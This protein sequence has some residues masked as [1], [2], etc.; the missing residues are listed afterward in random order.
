MSEPTPEQAWQQKLDS[1][2]VA[3][4]KE[5]DH[6]AK[7][8]IQQ[9]IAEARAKL[10]EIRKASATAPENGPRFDISRIDKF[11]PALLVGRE[12][13]TALLVDAWDRAVRD[14]PNRPRVLTFVALG[15]EGKTSLVAKWA[16]QL[17]GQ[18]WPGCE[19]CFAW[20]FYSQGTRD[21]VAASSDLFLQVAL[22]F[23]GDDAD[24][25]FAVS[26]AA[27]YEKGQRLARAVGRRRCLLIL[28]GLEPL[29]YAPTAPTPGELKDQGVSALLRGLAADSRGLCVV[30]T[31]HSLPDLKAFWQST[32]REEKLH[33]LSRP[34]G[35]HLLKT[36][37]V[38]GSDQR[39]VPSADGR[40]QL[41]EFE[42]L[43]EDARGHALT[44]TLLGTFLAEFHGG[45]IRRRDRVK[46]KEA[47]AT[48][49][50]PH[51]AWRVMD[52]YVRA[53]AP[54]GL[55]AWVRRLFRRAAR[56][57][58]AEG[59]RAVSVLR[60]VGFFDRP[61]DAGCFGA[62]WNAPAIDGLT[63]SLVGL[64]EPHRNGILKRLEDARLVTVN[65]DAG[66][67]LVSVDA[68][69]L[70]REYFAAQLREAKSGAW[71][72]GHRRLFEH[73][74]ATTTEGQE[75]TLDALQPLYQAVAHGCHAGMHR[76]ACATVYF[77]RIQRGKEG[78]STHKL[79]AF[80]SDLGA[81]TCFFEAPWGRV[82]AAFTEVDQA[83]LLNEA[84]TRLR[85]LGRL[86]EA[87]EPTRIALQ[88]RVRQ[89]KWKN[90]A[91]MASNLSQLRL[92]LGEVSGAAGDAQQSVA[93]ADRS[94][95]AFQRMSKRTTHADALHQWGRRDEALALFRQAE[96]MQA[97]DQP[98]YPQLY[99][100][101]GF[102]YCD[103]LL[104]AAERA[105]WGP[106][107]GVQVK[108]DERATCRDVARHA[109]RT[110][111][112]VESES[113]LLDIAL[114]HLT[115]GR[116]ALLEAL[117]GG[118]DF[119]IA[120]A[121]LDAAVSGL[122]RAGQQY[123]LP[124]GLLARAWLRAVGGKRTGPDS[125]Q[126]DLDEAWEIAERGPMPLHMADIHLYR[127]RLF[128]REPAYPWE[129][130]AAD[131]A[132]AEKLIA[133]CGYHRRDEELADAKRL[134]LPNNVKMLSP[135]RIEVPMP[136]QSS[137]TPEDRS[138]PEG[139]REP[140][141]G[142]GVPRTVVVLATGWGPLY[143]GINAF[144]F[145]LCHALGTVLKGAARLVCVTAGV[146]DLT[147]SRAERDHLRLLTLPKVGPGDEVAVARNARDL[148]AQNGITATDLVIGHDVVTGPAAVELCALTGGRS[149]V[150]HH[151]SYGEYQ[152]VKKDGRT[153]LQMEDTQ[154]ELLR[155]AAVVLAV[156]PLLR[157]SAEHLVG[158]AV[159]M[160]VPGLAAI[161]P[162]ER[163]A[164]NAFRGIAFGRLGGEDD[165]I[166]QGSLAV[167]GYG[168]YVK[169][170]E[171]LN[172]DRDHRFTMYGLPPDRYADEE[173]A[174]K[175]LMRQEAGRQIAVNATVY[176]DDRAKLYAALAD[177]EVALMLSWHE[178][179]GLVGW[180]AIAAEVPLVVSRRTGLYKL[181][182]DDPDTLGA[183]CVTV[184]HVRG[185]HN[186]EPDPADIEDV[187]LAL[188]RLS[189]NLPAALEKARK[190][191]K[192][193][194]AKYTWESCAREVLRA[195]GWGSERTDGNEPPAPPAPPHGRT[196]HEA[197]AVG[198][199]TAVRHPSDSTTGSAPQAPSSIGSRALAPGATGAA[200]AAHEAQLLPQPSK[201]N[202]SPRA[203]ILALFGRLRAHQFAKLCFLLEVP[204]GL[205]PP[206]TVNHESQSNALLRWAAEE[207][208]LD[209]LLTFLRQ[210]VERS[211]RP[212]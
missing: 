62:L 193:L 183:D 182:T 150:F 25:A 184:V 173:R 130:P 175:E 100:L 157:E 27:A 13:E 200:P 47:D 38:W 108:E 169:K 87:L 153:A 163:R 154:R 102:Q 106:A 17:A 26:S 41:S 36:L 86:T 113:W 117:L 77:D 114:D 168:R 19:G 11:A 46:L 45:D 178:G 49:P 177:S 48:G 119:G 107:V 24:R 201:T 188:L 37:G 83:W 39:T 180:E 198:S 181:L 103:L 89:E 31:R 40:E 203:E 166:K 116:V 29:Q 28:D 205:Q 3:E 112:W 30:T 16:A 65:R 23:L 191:R 15:G 170:A 1:L 190:L 85:A 20:S 58:H 118:S 135:A 109:N 110:L 136:S 10:A 88:M 59:R 208:R 123:Y 66:G 185:S 42:K 149:V 129:S 194:A 97:Q 127:A 159:P 92:A 84:A 146:D 192:H 64:S 18:G 5:S 70:V 209:D 76:Q 147:R 14:Q 126:E 75:P 212:Q 206:D 80:A 152:A 195:C 187:S 90:A 148:L 52:A 56:E 54:T 82:W 137:V 145:D 143:G 199:G 144:S 69:P 172:L 2:Q 197:P 73:L 186:G 68:H 81:V 207:G 72:E 139:A 71:R 93:F 60:L 63:E 158:G 79:G 202:A 120:R 55:R 115:L 9:G 44:L 121:E 155:R 174:V 128:F 204:A 51:H 211:N 57:A 131:L 99:S 53:L 179:F 12:T 133:K 104:S 134:I 164:R 94:G 156:G 140:H 162:V 138:R 124:L 96:S 101:A 165:P 35:V 176:T 196:E 125:A 6:E 161:T 21:Q 141:G 105:A 50:R 22:T 171:E 4:A 33:R 111:Q 142:A 34:A 43:V 8:K 95:D 160:V 122:R 32:A 98:E 7:F 61:T 210:L 132:A 189:T 151:M 67:R 167:A 74:C 91:I 78:Y